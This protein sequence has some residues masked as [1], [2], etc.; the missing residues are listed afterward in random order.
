MNTIFS[1]VDENIFNFFSKYK[2]AKE[3]W[4]IFL[5]AHEGTEKVISQHLRMLTTMFE[6]MDM[7]E[8]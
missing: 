5:V 1:D 2:V 8:E 7:K 3:S 6:N 4:D